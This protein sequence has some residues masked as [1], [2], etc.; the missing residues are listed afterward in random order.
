MRGLASSTATTTQTDILAERTAEMALV[1]QCDRCD[2]VSDLGTPE[3]MPDDWATFKM[4]VRGSEGRR[5]YME[6]TLCTECDDSLYDWFHS[7]AHTGS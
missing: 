1:W 7:A 2:K 6:A 4:P 3:D 5:S